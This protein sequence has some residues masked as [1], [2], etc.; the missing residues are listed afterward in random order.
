M[1]SHTH[2]RTNRRQDVVQCEFAPNKAGGG[3]GGGSGS[4]GSSG[5]GDG[6]GGQWGWRLAAVGAARGEALE[7]ASGNSSISPFR[8]RS[9]VRGL[10]GMGRLGVVVPARYVIRTGDRTEFP[11]AAELPDWAALLRQNVD[12]FALNFDAILSAMYALSISAEGD[13]YLCM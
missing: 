11:D 9:S 4:G 2:T 12:I 13:C 3:G 1:H 8:L 6:S 10:L 7:V 5:G